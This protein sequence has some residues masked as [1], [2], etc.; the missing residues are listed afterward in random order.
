MRSQLIV[1]SL[2]LWIKVCLMNIHSL[3]SPPM[4][5]P[6]RPLLSNYLHLRLSYN[7]IAICKCLRRESPDLSLNGSAES[8]STG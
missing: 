7:S 5:A 1:T 2:S 3:L 4:C 6:V 8:V